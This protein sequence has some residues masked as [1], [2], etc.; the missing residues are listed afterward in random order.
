MS[1]TKERG[2]L[3][4]FTLVNILESTKSGPQ[5]SSIDILGTY[6]ERKDLRATLIFGIRICI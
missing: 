2:R 6:L 5:T 3:I 4:S 1:L